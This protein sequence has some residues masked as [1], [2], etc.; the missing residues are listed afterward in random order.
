VR[1]GYG[2]VKIN[3]ALLGSCFS[4]S[5]GPRHESGVGFSMHNSEMGRLW[6]PRS[7]AACKAAGSKP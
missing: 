2:T 6:P 3:L 7:T 1:R 5:T 4:L